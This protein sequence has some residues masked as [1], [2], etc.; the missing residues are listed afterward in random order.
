MPQR[1]VDPPGFL[2]A[3]QAPVL[4]QAQGRRRGLAFGVHP[5]IFGQPL[6]LFEQLANGGQQVLVERWVEE[7]QVVGR[8]RLGFQISQGIGGLDLAVG[9]PQGAQ[10]LLQAGH[11]DAA[12]VQRLAHGR[13]TGQGFEEPRAAA[14]FV[15]VFAGAGV[16]A[17]RQQVGFA[18]TAALGQRDA[19]PAMIAQSFL[20][21]GT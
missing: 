15:R 1:I 13:A 5:G 19:S 11:R 20:H 12:G 2:L 3:V 8:C 4:R 9:A 7:H 14:G 16:V 6:A 10:V 21:A 17:A 18:R